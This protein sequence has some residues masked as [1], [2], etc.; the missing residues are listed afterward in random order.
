[1]PEEFGGDLTGAEFWGADLAGA[2]FR[3]VNLTGARISHAWLVDVEIDANVE[4]LTINGVDVTE[5]VNARDP[6]FRVRSAQRARTPDE[7]RTAWVD[8]T[9]AWAPVIDR[10]RSLPADVAH[11]RVADEW[12]FVETLRHLLM[13]TDKWFTAPIL[14]GTFHPYGLANT[15]S[16]AFPF[17]GLDPSSDP[18]LDDVLA[19]RA[20][21]GASL[22]EYLRDVTDDE[23]DRTVDVLENG[24]HAIRQCLQTVFEEE[25]W[26]LRYAHRDLAT[27]TGSVT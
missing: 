2:T 8:V 15:G 5:Y 26:H 25:F 20:E 27:L 18:S 6:W 11:A 16:A 13:A 17:P 22:G 21:R 1:M 23:L 24:P 19:A 14:G 4:G 12:S 3:D 9:D 7:V 10:V